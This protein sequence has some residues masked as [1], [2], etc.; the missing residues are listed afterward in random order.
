MR[1]YFLP[2]KWYNL[3]AIK[4]ETQLEEKLKNILEHFEEL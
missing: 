2:G 3:A 4:M 1:V